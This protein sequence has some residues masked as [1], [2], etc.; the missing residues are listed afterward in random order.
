MN[1]VILE[2]GWACLDCP[3]HGDGEGSDK[4]AEKHTKKENHST[5]SWSKPEEA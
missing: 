5:R 4:A 2:Y 1:G 3:E